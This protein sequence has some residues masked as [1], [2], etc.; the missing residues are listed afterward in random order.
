VRLNQQNASSIAVWK[1]SQFDSLAQSN[2]PFFKASTPIWL[3]LNN[4]G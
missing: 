2:A 1:L 3:R 4:N